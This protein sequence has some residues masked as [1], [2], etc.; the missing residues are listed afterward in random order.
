MS[1]YDKKRNKRQPHF[2]LS[3]KAFQSILSTLF[4]YHRSLGS[5][6]INDG[7]TVSVFPRA[8]RFHCPTIG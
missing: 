5:R 3:G 4:T 2:K 7:Y 1:G 6:I 8:F